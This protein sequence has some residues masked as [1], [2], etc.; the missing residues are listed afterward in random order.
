MAREFSRSQRMGPLILRT[1]NEVIRSDLNDTG[2]SGV[3]LTSI[4]LS[5]DLSIAKI[6]FSS[7]QFNDEI[8]IP[9]EGLARASGYL[10][11]KLGSSIK[12]RHVP[13]LRFF[14]DDSISKGIE[15]SSLIDQAN[16]SKKIIT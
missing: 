4:D 5:H 7:I 11:K 13:E 12:I 2:L 1:L 3:S 10:R 14:H 9:M 6:Y 16:L 8:H 15:I